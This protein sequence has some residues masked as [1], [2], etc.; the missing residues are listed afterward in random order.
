M[1]APNGDPGSAGQG[2]DPQGGTGAPVDAT[3]QPQSGQQTGIGTEDGAQGQQQP[4]KS[5]AELQAELEATRRRMTAADQNSAKYQAELKKLQDA[6]LS[7]QDKLKRDFADAQE[8]ITKLQE[9]NKRLRVENHFVTDSTYNWHDPHA[10]LKLA[11]LSD[12]KF[13][14]AGKPSGLTEAMKA[15]AEAHP[16]LLK[17][18]EE[19][20]SGGTPPAPPAGSTGVNG[21]PGNQPNG[22]DRSALEKRFPA[23]RGRVSS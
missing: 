19:G 7:E 20:G 9:E 21:R 1:T 2:S 6:Q 5:V 11:N 14:D 8:T 22:P 13:D 17:P 23:M 10:A 18:K 15:V 3:G 4:T 16:F 12:V